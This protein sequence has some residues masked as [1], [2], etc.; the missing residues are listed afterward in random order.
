MLKSAMKKY[1]DALIAFFTSAITA[2]FTPLLKA[3]IDP[4]ALAV[5]VSCSIGAATFAILKFVLGEMP[6]RSR[7]LRQWHDRSYGI[8]G[9][10]FEQV[11]TTPNHPYS[12]GRIAWNLDRGTFEYNG[13]NVN[14]DF[15]LNAKWYSKGDLKIEDQRLLEFL[16]EAKIFKRNGIEVLS[17]HGSLQ[18]SNYDYKN[19]KYWNGLGNFSATGNRSRSYTLTMQRIEKKLIKKLPHQ[20]VRSDEDMIELI[21]LFVAQ[22]QKKTA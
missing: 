2:E 14:Q 7:T 10:W 1:L 19:R 12:C 13:V 22:N 9:Y 5:V 15:T 4:D 6:M 18:F 3:N 8:E 20:E 16:F 17:G 21:K 11:D